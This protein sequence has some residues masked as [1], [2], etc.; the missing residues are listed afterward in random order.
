MRHDDRR[1]RPSRTNKAFRPYHAGPAFTAVLLLATVFSGSA[2]ALDINDTDSLD[3]WSDTTLDFRVE[4]DGTIR[5]QNI[6]DMNGNDIVGAGVV[7]GATRGQLSGEQNIVSDGSFETGGM[8]YWKKNPGSISTSQV[9]NGSYSLNIP[10]KSSGNGHNDVYQERPD[11]AAQ[12]IKVKP[13]ETYA[14]QGYV[15]STAGADAADIGIR[16]YDGSR[17][18]VK[19][20]QIT[21]NSGTG[22]W[23]FTRGYWTVPSGSQYARIWLRGDDQNTGGENYFDN[24][25]VYRVDKPRL[26]MTGKIDMN[27]NKITNLQDPSNA[28]DAATKSYVDNNDDTGTDSQDLSN[29]LDT[30]PGVGYVEHGIQITGGSDTVARDYYE[31]DTDNQGL[32]DVLSND[33]TA[34]QNIDFTGSNGITNDGSTDGGHGVFPYIS[35]VSG[36]GNNGSA[37]YSSGTMLGSDAQILFA[38]TDGNTIQGHINTNNAVLDMYGDVRVNGNSVDQGLPS[39]LSNDNS[40]S[41]NLQINTDGQAL[42]LNSDNNP[43]DTIQFMESGTAKWSLD[44]TNEGLKF[45]DRNNGVKTLEMTAGNNV[46]IPNGD[47]NMN[48]N[49][50]QNI[51]L[52]NTNTINSN[53]GSNAI[54]VQNDGFNFQNG[55]QLEHSGTTAIDLDSS[56]NVKIANGQLTVNNG[57]CHNIEFQPT[58]GLISSKRNNSQNEIYVTDG[59]HPWSSDYGSLVFEA[60]TSKGQI[61]FATSDQAGGGGSIQQTLKIDE[62]GTVRIPNGNLDMTGSGQIVGL[63]PESKGIRWSLNS[64]QSSRQWAK[65]QFDEANGENIGWVRDAYKNQ[66]FKVEDNTNSNNM[67]VVRDG[68]NIQIPNGNLDMSGNSIT[69]TDSLEFNGGIEIGDSGTTAGS[70]NAVAVGKEASASDSSALAAGR[71]ADASGIA[72]LAFGRTASASANY[73]S[74]FGDSASASGIAASAFGSLAGASAE[75]AV[76]IGDQA[77]APNQYEATFGNLNGEELDVN[78]T[79]DLTV[80]GNS[81]VYGSK[82]FVQQVNE[83]HE[84]VYT[85]QESPQVRAVLESTGSVV[86]GTAVVELPRHFAQVVSDTRPSLLVQVTPVGQGS[87]PVRVLNTTQTGFVV[88]QM[89]GEPR[90]FTVNYRITGIRDGYEDKQVVQQRNEP[91][92]TSPAAG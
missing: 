88:E 36:Y 44:Y 84:V 70:T 52:V 63:N 27:S 75:G 37:P 8:S 10:S 86:N 66:A 42:R 43:R 72:A 50:I 13:G 9:L 3:Y 69:G 71:R 20:A 87:M 92:S 2:A 74:A 33:N 12:L 59:S 78:V 53:R 5:A 77:E 85:S 23:E 51:D 81:N 22:S 49:K 82:N 67:L 91:Q 30:S 39:V 31:A 26:E 17:S 45:Q 14:V 58:G 73:A 29:N 38:E 25:R 32:P 61:I 62:A 90:N 28:Q 15:Y 46:R 34:D 1:H 40:A 7:E 65:I 48:G 80:H 11:G 16:E 76:A 55:G 18:H 68:G 47:L 79:G 41:Q 57:C 19:W 24:I 4:T 60:P 83:S 56:Q 54:N 6:L 64:S 35:D 89:L 21:S